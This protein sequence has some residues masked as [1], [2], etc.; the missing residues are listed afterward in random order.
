MRR[1]KDRADPG[2]PW[3]EADQSF[4]FPDPEKADSRGILCSGGNLSPGMLLS[5]YGQGIFPW[6][7]RDDPILWWSPNPRFVL[8]PKR[9]HVSTTMR[10]ILRQGRYKL[11]LDRAFGQVIRACQKSPRPGQSGTWI[12]DDMVEAYERLYELGFAHS[13][14]AWLDGE[15]AGGLYGVALGGVFFGESMFSHRDDAS[16]A[17]FIPLVLRLVDEGFIL[18]DSQVYT[19][20]VA[21]LGGA[22][23]AREDYLC[24]L[25]QGLALPGKAGNWGR[26]FTGYPSSRGYDTL[27]AGRQ[28]GFTTS[29]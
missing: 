19:D 6:F 28:G 7:N 9:L 27:I 20:H 29:P 24:L 10:K 1:Q 17:A 12:Q 4:R 25:A 22:E 8:F 3:L 26:L 15:L 21:G 11:S 16:K 5:A 14:E 13:A 2:F 23:I 18:I